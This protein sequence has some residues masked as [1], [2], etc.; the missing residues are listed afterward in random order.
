MESIAL[1]FPTK[2]YEK[3]ILD[4]KNEFETNGD[5][6]DGTAGLQ[7]IKDINEWFAMLMDNAK[8]ET[9]RE[10]RVPA[11]TY[12]AVRRSDNR[13]IG[14]IDIRHRLNEYL[15]QFGGH[16]GYSVRKSER[17]KGYAK[18]MLRLALEE[19]KTMNMEKVLIT[20]NK[21]NIASAKTTICNGGVLENEVLEGER[22][23]Q[24]YWIDLL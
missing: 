13:V 17:Q 14:M 12:L 10:G 5:S 7:R 23:T 24:R 11:S 18:E 19:C 20:C 2:E 4:Y 21:E 16:I 9:V 1:I 22:I 3:Q 15:F 8:E 6:M